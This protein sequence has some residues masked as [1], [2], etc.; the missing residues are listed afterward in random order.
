MGGRHM[1]A[2][3]REMTSSNLIIMVCKAIRRLAASPILSDETAIKLMYRATFHKS[4][5]LDNPIT[6][7]EKLQWMK[8]Y[9]RNPLYTTLVDKAALKKWAAKKIGDDRVLPTLGVWHQFEDINFDS[10][11]NQ[12]VLKCTHDSG[13]VVICKNST[14]FDKRK[15][16]RR[17]TRALRRDYYL[18]GREWPYKNVPRRIICEP[19]VESLANGDLPDY[20]F[21]CFDGTPKIM[22]VATGRQLRSE[23]YFDFFDMDFNR[24]D[25]RNG[26]P[27]SPL[28]KFDKPYEFETMKQF[29]SILSQGIPFVR[30]DFYE[31]DGKAVLGEMTF[32]HDCGFE[33][34][35]PSSWDEKLGSWLNL[36][37]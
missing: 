20:K 19:Y 4:L 26:H 22:Y 10:L 35:D 2:S 33:P 31:V 25:I 27:N 28:S 6:F 15:A 29:A 32:F 8:L 17:L 7:N 34:F 24:L 30:V 1:S 23:P 9:D 5:D 37:R 18:L 3:I 21:F 12:F 11:P 16:R 14:Q 13:S 36:S